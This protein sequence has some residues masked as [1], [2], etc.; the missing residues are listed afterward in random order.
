MTKKELFDNLQQCLGRMV[1]PFELEDIN[2]WVEDGLPP[3]VINKTPKITG[4]G[5]LYFAD[6]LLNVDDNKKLS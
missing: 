1:T 3:E 6:K 5:Q 2:K 4:K